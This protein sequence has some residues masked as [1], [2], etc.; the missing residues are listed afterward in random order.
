MVKDCNI[1]KLMRKRASL[2]SSTLRSRPNDY[3]AQ[4]V[5]AIA[6][7]VVPHFADGKLELVIDKVFNLSDVAT[8]FAE[9]SKNANTGKLVLK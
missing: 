8:A 3:K 2:L 5:K 7:N 4:L 9:M 6:D 1:M